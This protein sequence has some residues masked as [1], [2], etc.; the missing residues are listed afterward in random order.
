M[1]RPRREITPTGNLFCP[2]CKQWKHISHYYPVHKNSFWWQDP[3]DLIWYGRPMTYCSDC[4]KER[5]KASY[6]AA[7]ERDR[8]FG[9]ND[10]F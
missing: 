5:N 9:W 1:S 8:L 10:G 6:E 3:K 7:K 4:A 2:N